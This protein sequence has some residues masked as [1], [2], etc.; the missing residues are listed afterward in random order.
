[1]ETRSPMELYLAAC[2][3]EQI[4]PPEEGPTLMEY[5][6]DLQRRAVEEFDQAPPPMVKPKK[7]RPDCHNLRLI[8]GGKS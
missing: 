7:R 3:G 6:E 1:M 2:E 4:P 8:W 5:L